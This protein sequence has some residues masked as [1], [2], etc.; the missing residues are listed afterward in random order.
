MAFSCS[1]KSSRWAKR[2]RS[3]QGRLTDSTR[4]T[5]APQWARILVARGAAATP[6]QVGHLEP[7]RVDDRLGRRRGV[8][9]VEP[10]PGARS[11]ARGWQVPSSWVSDPVRVRRPGGPAVRLG[12]RSFARGGGGP[13]QS[14]RTPGRRAVGCRAR[15]WR[16]LTGQI[17]RLSRNPLRQLGLGLGLGELADQV[18]D[19]LQLGN[20]LG[21]VLDVKG[22]VHPVFVERGLVAEPS[23]WTHSMNR[24]NIGP[25][26]G[27]NEM[28]ITA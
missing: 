4:T 11:T 8:R 16:S 27:P 19:P 20:G 17:R 6:G 12:P 5:V 1:L 13:R 22:E 14:P 21:A 7:G 9:R 3:R 10:A 2:P 28:V 18:H 15:S 26:I 25:I 23:S 24:R